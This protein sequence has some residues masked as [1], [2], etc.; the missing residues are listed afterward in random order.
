MANNSKARFWLYSDCV[1][2]GPAIN[3]QNNCSTQTTVFSES[4]FHRI[5]CL[6]ILHTRPPFPREI[7]MG[8]LHSREKIS[9]HSVL[10][11]PYSPTPHSV[12]C[13][14]LGPGQPTIRLLVADHC[15]K[16]K[17]NQIT[18]KFDKYWNTPKSCIRVDILHY[19]GD[20]RNENK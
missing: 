3:Y 4:H 5:T 16:S 6:S 14:D 13:W 7:D 9:L 18:S 1:W 10:L 17:W 11:A 2:C 15:V 19:S 8:K 12:L 20:V